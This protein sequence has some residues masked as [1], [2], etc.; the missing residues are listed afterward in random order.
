MEIRELFHEQ[1]KLELSSLNNMKRGTDEYIKAVKAASIFAND[2]LKFDDQKI[3]KDLKERELELKE[4]ELE[5]KER[6]F[7]SEVDIKKED[8]K[9]RNNEQSIKKELAEKE[10]CFKEKELAAKKE[11]L[12]VKSK[13]IDS[14]LVI[15]EEDIQLRQD[16]LEEKKVQNL[17][18]RRFEIIREITD[19]AKIVLPLAVTIWGTI[20][21]LT[22][23][24]TGSVTTI[25]GRAHANK[26]LK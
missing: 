19:T 17:K 25:A 18:S 24:K 3:E 11:E 9:L 21:T 2:I 26:A 20:V 5:L 16:E 1:L 12:E 7:E 14:E 23:E 15:K 8:I 13:Q 4:K 6:T 22:F 10:L